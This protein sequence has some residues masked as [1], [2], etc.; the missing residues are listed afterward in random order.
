M[1]L[2]T[3]N[4]L[5]G[6]SV[7]GADPAS[8]R[9]LLDERGRPIAPAPVL[10]DAPLRESARLLDADVVGLQE[11]DVHQERSGRAH[12]V[13]SVA[14]ALDAPFWMFVPAVRGTPG[15]ERD[16]LAADA[17]DHRG[18]DDDPAD[19]GPR[20]GVG[21]VSRHPVLAW[22]ATVFDA[23]PWSLPLVI[24]AAPRPRVM[25]IPDEPR[26][27][28]AALVD[29]PRGLITVATAHLSFVPGYNVR[30]L[31]RLRTWLAD[32]PRP[33][34]LLGD[35]NLPGSLP[36]RIT[37]WSPLVSAPTYPST[38][39]RVQFDHVL[40]DGLTAVQLASVRSEVHTLPVSDHCAVS[41]DLTL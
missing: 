11:V 27:A 22:R 20:Y 1:R 9:P 25:R 34:V 26:V 18:H 17:V 41:V 39:P 19:V 37:G 3:F 23:A 15:L 14:E 16:W 35:F 28:V 5:H 7:S 13:R 33:L 21:L 31:R 30:Q 38:G 32:L 4:L 36:R 12:Q 10:S 2:A 24:P 6:V 8:L 29:T 40:A